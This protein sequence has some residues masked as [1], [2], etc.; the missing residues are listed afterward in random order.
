MK[1]RTIVATAVALL[2]SAVVL[3][4][5]NTDIVLVVVLI[6]LFSL[7]IAYAEGCEKL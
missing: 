6:V 2:A 1:E 7:C 5:G 3:G 4:I